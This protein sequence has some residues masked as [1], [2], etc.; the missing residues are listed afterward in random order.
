M[1]L[2]FCGNEQHVYYIEGA[3]ARPQTL[4]LPSNGACAT[5]PRVHI[6]DLINDNDTVPSQNRDSATYLLKVK[7]M[8]SAERQRMM[9]ALR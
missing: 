2:L 4:F 9:V 8:P 5:L 6:R 1:K 3:S 7:M